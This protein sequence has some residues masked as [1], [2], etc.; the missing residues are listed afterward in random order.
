MAG[1]FL[2]IA[3]SGLI[4]SQ[5]AINTVSHNIANA[6]NENYT[7]QRTDID[8]RN[9]LFIGGNF[10]G[11]GA[12]LTAI[13]RVFD[14][15]VAQELHANLSAFNQENIFFSQVSRIDSIVADSS[16][17]LSKSIQDF[18]A[19][20][21]GVANDPSSIAAR[22]VFVGQADLLATRFNSLFQELDSQTEV[23]NAGLR[24]TAE[25]I[26]AL[27]QTIAELNVKIAAATGGGQG[28]PNDLLDEREALVNDL[29][30]LVETQTL[31]LDDGTISVFVGTGQSLVVGAVSNGL[32]TARSPSDPRNLE[33]VLQ[34]G[35][36]QITVTDGITGGKIGGYLKYR[37]EIV[38]P[39]LN[40]IGRVAMAV[41]E[42]FNNQHR[43]GM[44]LNNDLG[45]DFFRDINDPAVTARRVSVSS[46]NT[47]TASFSVSIDD[48]SVMQDH[49]YDL[50]FDGAN[51]QVTN[52][53]T[54]TIV[55]T[56]PAP[57][58]V[59]STIAFPTEGFSLT[60]NSGAANAGDQFTI[61]PTRDGAS[62]MEVLV[63]DPNK[64]AAAFP[65]NAVVGNNIGSGSIENVT[66][67][68]TT[69]AA[70]TTT[71]RALT[72]PVRFEF[73]SPTSFNVVN[74]TT[75]AVITGPVAGFVPNQDNDMLALAGLN[76]GYDIT[77][78]GEPQTNDTFSVDYNTDGFGDNRNMLMLSDLQQ[79]TVLD[80]G[81][82]TFQSGFSR[83]VSQVGTETQ[84]SKISLA[85][86]ESL[87]NQV[88][89]RRESVSGVNLDEEAA[90][91]IKLE[92][93]YQASARVIS[94]AQTLFQ[95][96]IDSFR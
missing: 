75:N 82:S 18:F 85:S 47:G 11:T 86:S 73:T 26:T 87:L 71:A 1:N 64:I 51:Y 48:L 14:I 7:R 76:F 12:E 22:Q 24:T 19:A 8:T 65:V 56:F 36:G 81:R 94:T 9:P 54:N 88:K 68:D 2:D 28:A 41:S 69:N 58:V 67:T 38:E 53:G 95:T 35:A 39:G 6:S 40:L 50:R 78:N 3:V 42:E 61:F 96:V 93:T 62:N 79:S 63:T 77:V 80:N 52:L 90:K 31:R 34:T 17:G 25:E 29:S 23:I 27:G 91:L 37:D 33:L 60:L 21:Q 45:G 49:N 13:T 15:T 32:V 16:N 84:A 43:L 70:F 74:A 44:D 59:P 83:L 46:L 92:Q 55:G 4:T 66:V 10:V 57:G 89:E 20:S 30:E 5:A 72:P